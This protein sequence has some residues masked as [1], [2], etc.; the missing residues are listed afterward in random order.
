MYKIVN[1]FPNEFFSAT[2]GPFVSLYQTTHKHS[3]ENK[4]DPIKFKNLI[5]EIEKSLDS[6]YPKRE[7]QPILDAFNQIANDTRFWNYTYDGIAVFYSNR[8]TIVYKF[9]RPVKDLVVVSNS[10]HIK[11]LIRKFQSADNYHVLGLNREGFTLFEGNRYGVEEVILDDD[12]PNNIKEVLGEDLSSTYISGRYGSNKGSSLGTGNYHGHGD[13]SKL[14]SIDTEKFFRFVDKT[15][16][17]N[18]S[19]VEK[20]PLVLVALPEYHSLFRKISNNPYLLADG[21]KANYDVFTIDSL[22]N[23]L[24]KLVEPSYIKKSDDLI[25]EFQSSRAK[26]LGS[27]DIAN[28][29]RESVSNKVKT[30]LI[31]SDR[32]VP[33]RVDKTTGAIELGELSHPE[34]GDLLNDLALIVL[35][36]G[37]NVVLVPKERMPTGTGIAATYRF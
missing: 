5:K 25:D 37:G 6:L 10:F 30:V 36:N 14:V 32:V 11:P 8:Q 23:E 2:E 16:L 4:Q 31:E 26:A 21:I 29:A 35:Q 3:P 18:Y 1:E 13:K 9:N 28:I 19:K 33:G 24:W 34:Y 17:E 15:I 27:D 12:I 7:K 20:I 22:K